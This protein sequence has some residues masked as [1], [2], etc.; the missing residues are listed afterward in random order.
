MQYIG[1]YYVQYFNFQ[2][3][4]TGTLWEGRYKATLLDSEGYLL[5]CSR[6]IELNPVRADMVKNPSE[7]PWS[8]FHYNALEDQGVSQLDFCILH[9]SYLRHV[10]LV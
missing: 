3:Q 9:F 2:Y 10:P 5:T 8:S 1:R 6:Y 7:Y 4:R